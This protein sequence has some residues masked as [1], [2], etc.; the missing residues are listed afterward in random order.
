MIKKIT[1]ALSLILLTLSCQNTSNTVRLRGTTDLGDGNK[2]LHVVA[3]FNNQPK[4]LDTASQIAQL[5][6]QPEQYY[7]H[8]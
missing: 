3:D 8:P 6:Y 2:I 4:I 7:P 5:A 1:S